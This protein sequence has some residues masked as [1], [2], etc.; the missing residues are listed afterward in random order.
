MHHFECNSIYRAII[1]IINPS[2]EG[3]SKAPFRWKMRRKSTSWSMVSVSAVCTIGYTLFTASLGKLWFRVKRL[4]PWQAKWN[5]RGER[6]SP[7]EGFRM[8][9][10]VEKKRES[11]GEKKNWKKER[12]KGGR[13]IKH[14]GRGKGLAAMCNFVVGRACVLCHGQP[15]GEN[16][17]CGRIARW[18]RWIE[19]KRGRG[20]KIEPAGFHW[21]ATYRCHGQ[22]LSSYLLG[23]HGWKSWRGPE[24]PGKMCFTRERKCRKKRVQ[25]ELMIHDGTRF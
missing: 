4:G 1:A 14:S 12:E 5:E 23:G 24:H 2:I 7:T 22:F 15:G 17:K 11:H 13:N 3:R 6:N 25:L 21:R 8:V 20:K 9:K 19:E 18:E 16:V 10:T